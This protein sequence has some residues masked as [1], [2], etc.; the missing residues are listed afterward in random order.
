MD[1][2]LKEYGFSQDII[3]EAC[4]RTIT[5]TGQPSFQYA[6]GILSNWKQEGVR[7]AA[8][9]TSLDTKHRELRQQ[10]PSPAKSGRT[11]SANRFNNFHQREYD[12]SQLEKQLLEKQL[13]DH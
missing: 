10:K 7:T 5:Q 1:R 12:Y 2:W 13:M 9:I 6:E 4:A 8:D 11:Q 3:A